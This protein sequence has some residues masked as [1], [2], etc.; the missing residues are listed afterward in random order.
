MTVHDLGD[1]RRRH[2]HGISTTHEVPEKTP[3]LRGRVG[4]AAPQRAAQSQLTCALTLL[5]RAHGC[6][7]TL[8]DLSVHAPVP[9]L[10]PE[11]R[12]RESAA[13]LTRLHPHAGELTVIDQSDLGE[14]IQDRA[15]DFGVG[16]TSQEISGEFLARPRSTRQATKDDFA[17]RRLRLRR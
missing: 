9:Q 12:T 7:G 5:I 6:E 8:D 1:D 16:A 17:Q 14:S 4:T 11:C 15:E 13:P 2:T 10:P 3:T